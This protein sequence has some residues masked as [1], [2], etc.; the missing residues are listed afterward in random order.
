MQTHMHI[1]THM[2]TNRNTHTYTHKHIFKMSEM[3]ESSDYEPRLPVSEKSNPLTCD[4]DRATPNQIVKLLEACDAQMF[5]EET[6]SVYQRFFSNSIVQTMLEISKQ[7]EIILKD[8]EDSIVVL[9]GCGTSGRLAYL[10]ATCFNR[11]L[12]QQSQE[13]QYCYIIA[14]GDRALLTSQEAPEDNPELGMLSL[15]KLC[16][17]KRHVLFIGISCGLS[18]PFVAGQ[19][20]FC[21]QHPDVYVP[22]LVGFNPVCQARTEPMPGSSL[23]FKGV[24]QRMQELQ[25]SQRAFIL[26]PAVGPEAVSGSSR[27]KGGSATKILL[28]TIL[29]A[30]HRAVYSHT[31][32]THSGVT[33]HL[34]RYQKSVELTY[35]HSEDIASLLQSA[36]FSLQRAGRVCYLGWGSLA[37]MGLIDASEC[38]PTF[39]ADYDDI[40]GFLSGGYEDMGNTEGPLSSLGPQFGISHKDFVRLVLP[41]LTDQDTVV[42]LCSH[43][44]DAVGVETMARRVRDRT[45]SLHVLY[46][47]QENG[48]VPDN[49]RSLCSSTLNIRWPGSSCGSSL[50]MWELSTKLVLNAVSTGAHILRGKVYRNHMIDLQVSNSKLYH[51]AIQLL[52]KLSGCPG[53]QCETALLKALYDTE[54][55]PTY[56]LSAS[57]NTHTLTASRRSKV[58]P[59]A[60]VCLLTGCSLADAKS[61]LD[62][63][64][65]LR[66]A[67][68]VC[69][70]SSPFGKP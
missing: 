4:I 70:A 53:C 56:V 10:L 33:E 2:L 16:E 65:V 31:P 46:H 57:L 39:G 15:M 40:R 69:Q 21:L 11:A 25:G 66:E 38:I 5:Q 34:R 47:G 52:Q 62:S 32:I 37:M 49:L 26:N 64:P 35:S 22:V 67:V 18:A 12:R 44:D 1:N 3:W 27:M 51:R 63:R 9:S 29:S 36:G 30:A 7:V 28:E 54:D 20:D 59:L 42:L 23:T 50:H 41:T 55:L 17:G 24:V 60:V 14:G 48:T 19:L 61:H 43:S 58:V 45:S 68:E 6:G 13:L 8:P